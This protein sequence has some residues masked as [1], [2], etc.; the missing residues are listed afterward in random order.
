M[1][2]PL[3]GR[4]PCPARSGKLPP[5]QHPSPSHQGRAPG[6]FTSLPQHLL[7]LFNLKGS[8]SSAYESLAEVIHDDSVRFRLK[9]GV[10]A[11]LLRSSQLH[12]QRQRHLANYISSIASVGSHAHHAKSVGSSSSLRYL[13]LLLAVCWVYE[14][15][16]CFPLGAHLPGQ[17]YLSHRGEPRHAAA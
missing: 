13:C 16:L 10:C 2:C 9:L 7:Q 8:Q 17:L 11:D 1:R 6:S 4:Q 5:P 15:L 12:H 3:G 14:E